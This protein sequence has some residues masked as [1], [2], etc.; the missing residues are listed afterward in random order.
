[1]T[2]EPAQYTDEG[3]LESESDIVWGLANI[4]REA[5]VKS[6]KAMGYLIRHTDLFA[7]VVRRISH[8]NY[9][10]SRKALRNLAITAR[11]RE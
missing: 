8:K 10:A 7:G 11:A 2:T 5:G 6:P 1:M 4:G 3:P 9:I